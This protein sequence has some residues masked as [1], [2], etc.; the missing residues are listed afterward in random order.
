M[1]YTEVGRLNKS[2]GIKG[3]I[4][5]IPKSGFKSDLERTGVWFVKKG[6]DWVPFFVESIEN[7]PHF[8]VKFE[9]IDSPEKARQITGSPLSLRDKDITH[10]SAPDDTEFRKL[11][12]FQ[13]INKGKMIGEINRVEEYPQQIMAILT[14]HASEIMMP[15]TTE[16]IKAIDPIDKTMEV[17]LPDGF[18]ES[19]Q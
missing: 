16:F 19:Q 13:V 9:D 8:L 2:F 11:I 14:T 15:L 7:D 5:V 1:A 12:G 18:V 6:T 3:F 4:K 17:E 10:S